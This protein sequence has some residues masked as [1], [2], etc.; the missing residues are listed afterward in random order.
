MW[1]SSLYVW[2]ADA[3][4]IKLTMIALACPLEILITNNYTVT[5]RGFGVL[6]FW[7]FGDSSFFL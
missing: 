7:G 3:I 2:V 6:G 1:E 4:F 5:L